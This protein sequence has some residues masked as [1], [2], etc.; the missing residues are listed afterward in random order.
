MS[1]ISFNGIK[2][3]FVNYMNYKSPYGETREV[4]VTEVRGRAG[5]VLTNI[6]RKPREIEVELIIDKDERHMKTLEQ[7]ADD[8]VDWLT[9]DTPKP[10]IFDREPDKIY[11]AILD[12]TIEKEYY[13]SFAK[14]TLKFICPDP[15]KY[16]TIG[17]KIL[18][19]QD[20]L[21][22][23][24]KGTADVP[25]I[26][27]A[28][29]LKNSSY[30]MIAKN[31]E[32]Y[33][34]IGDDDT[35]KKLADYTPLIFRDDM[36]TLVGWAKQ[37]TGTINDVYTGGLN[38]AKYKLADDKDSIIL[39]ESS[40]DENMTG[41]WIGAEYK[42]SLGRS[43]KDFISTVTIKVDQSK[44]GTTHF[45]QYIFDEN[46]RVIASLGY[47]NSSPRQLKGKIIVTLFDENGNQNKIYEY[48]NKST[49]YNW[50][51]IIIYIQL[52]RVN[53]KFTIKSWKH[54][55]PKGSKVGRAYDVYQTQWE[56][57]GGFYQRNIVS[58]SEYTAKYKSGYHMPTYVLGAQNREVLPQPPR[59][60][61][62]IIKKDDVITVDMVNRKVD[63]NGEPVTNLKTMLSDYFNL[64]RGTN[65]CYTFPENTFS[66]IAYWQDRYK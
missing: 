29:A 39:D 32:E 24:T 63:I 36:K 41:D 27:E 40:I 61:D 45:A 48:E 18:S 30:F 10:L 62:Y 16:A 9:T 2:K 60:R 37:T 50:K 11:F 55:R 21:L 14:A 13:V 25:A 46:N 6:S 44:G 7:T 23:E 28:T 4:E 34:M 5:G 22:L 56:D 19:N 57:V 59:T 20:Q 65:N 15:Y 51:E 66:T 3:P 8:V 52:V 31:D 64:D 33:F 35:S 17:N 53:N 42:K 47:V 26:F 1:N 49:F 43:V 58:I 38:G 12:G 54:Y